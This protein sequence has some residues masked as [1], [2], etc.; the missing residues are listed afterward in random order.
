MYSHTI[1]LAFSVLP[2]MSRE[3]LGFQGANEPAASKG[4]EGKLSGVS[5]HLE[6]RKVTIYKPSRHAMQSAS[7]KTR[8]W[9]LSWDSKPTWVNPLMGWTSSSDTTSQLHDLAFETLEDAV[10]Y[11]ER[12]G[13]AFEVEEPPEAADFK[14][15]KDYGLNFLTDAIKVGLRKEGERF[16]DHGDNAHTSAWVNLKRSKYGND[17]WSDDSWSKYRSTVPRRK[18]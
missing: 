8:M 14:G 4:E 13:I 15:E 7:Y 5:Q 18:D 17:N 3:E 9:K 2:Y 16:F 1:S 12:Q 10:G 11:C 6:E